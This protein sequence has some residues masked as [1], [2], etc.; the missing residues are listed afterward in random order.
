MDLEQVTA[1]IWAAAERGEYYPAEWS[2]KLSLEDGYR[3]QL[4]TLARLERAG[5]RR[6]G[7]KVG[8][9][10]PA[11]QEQFGVHEPVFGFLLE[12]GA[13]ESGAVFEHRAL[14]RPGFENELCLTVGTTLRGPGVT[15]E[16]ARDAIAAV[17]PALEI[18]EN[19]GDLTGQLAL[20][21]ADNAQQK[22]F[23]TG[24]PTTHPPGGF[25][26]AEAKVEV[27]V[28]GR[29]VDQ[30]LGTAVLGDPAASIAW[31]ANKLAE[32]GLRLEAGMRVMAGSFTRQHLLEPGDAVEARFEPF[33]TVRVEVH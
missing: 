14:I 28:K 10:A 12:S 24:P 25:R 20:A 19:R 29:S 32:F 9:T 23:V 27:F 1:S 7:W 5:E 13:R 26:L 2:G 15:P 30:G 4:A 21:L 33:G 11:I 22:A 6:A 16:A 8:L 17:A 31:L 18:V 3:V